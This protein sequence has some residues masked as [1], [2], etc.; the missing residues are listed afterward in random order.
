M[1]AFLADLDAAKSSPEPAARLAILERARALYGGDFVDDCPFY[2][3]SV[4]VEEQRV[5]L[6]GRATDLRIAIGE[7]YEAM[8]DRLSA[9]AA[10][11]EAIRG[12]PAGSVPAQA[13]IARLGL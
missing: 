12:E 5:H 1:A 7:A 13:G 10:F 3:D 8:G 2:G 4:E 11:R 9:A 6:R